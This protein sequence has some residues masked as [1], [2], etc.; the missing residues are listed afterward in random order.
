MRVHNIVFIREA[1]IIIKITKIITVGK[2]NTYCL[3][4][5]FNY[6][7]IT[8]QF[9][10]FFNHSYTVNEVVVVAGV[11]I[12]ND[13]ENRQEFNLTRKLEYPGSFYFVF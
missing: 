11:T 9:N 10:T 12:R 3:K 5:Q 2:S 4:V 13:S 1:A 6:L 7:I 8:L